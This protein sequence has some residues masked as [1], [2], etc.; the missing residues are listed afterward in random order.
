MEV[1]GQ[2]HARVA[3]REKFLQYSFDRWLG[4]SHSRSGRGGKRK[5]LAPVG[6]R[7]PIVKP[8]A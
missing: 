1:G 3:P 7:T 8:V 2:L 4:G 6:N 5:I